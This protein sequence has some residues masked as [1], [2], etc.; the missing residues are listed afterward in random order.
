MFLLDT[1]TIIYS[2]K[3]HA[4]VIRNLETHQLDPLGISAISL[5]ELYCGAFKS[6]KVTANLAKVRYIENGFEI[7]PID[8]SIAETF[9]MIKSSLESRGTPLDDFDLA[10][11]ASALTHNLTLVTNNEKHFRRVEGLKLANWTRS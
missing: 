10:I 2:L 8:A 6:D 4:A 11:A 1:D 5:M 7:L 9:G 3:G